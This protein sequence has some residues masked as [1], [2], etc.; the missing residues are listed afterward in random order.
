[1]KKSM[2]R[3]LV[4]MC[5]AFASVTPAMA[6]P[7]NCVIWPV[8][9]DEESEMMLFYCEGHPETPPTYDCYQYVPQFGW[10]DPDFDLWP[11]ECPDCVV[12]PYDV[13]KIDRPMPF[14]LK[15]NQSLC[16]LV[17]TSM[18]LSDGR[19]INPRQGLTC[20]CPR[21]IQVRSA[22]GQQVVSVRLFEATINP[23]CAGLKGAPRTI[24]IGFETDRPVL[25]TCRPFDSTAVAGSPYHA[26]VNYHGKDFV[27]M[28]NTAMMKQSLASVID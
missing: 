15:G 4:A 20:V 17:P 8:M 22:D 6:L 11:E 28:T 10:F 26:R 24:R 13:G 23:C 25:S 18:K 5:C 9:F 12:V 1:M 14:K 21:D 27:V 19:T 16:S 3:V 7:L 2:W